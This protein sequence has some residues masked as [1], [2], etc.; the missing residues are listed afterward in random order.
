MVHHRQA[1]H[2]QAKKNKVIFPVEGNSKFISPVTGEAVLERVVSVNV[3]SQG[4]I[5]LAELP[6]KFQGAR[7]NW[8]IIFTGPFFLGRLLPLLTNITK[9]FVAN[10]QENCGSYMNALRCISV[11]TVGKTLVNLPHSSINVISIT[12]KKPQTPKEF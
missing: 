8:I 6:G 1:K 12:R 7:A 2:K 4:K 5:T 10:E 9:V 11:P 3:L